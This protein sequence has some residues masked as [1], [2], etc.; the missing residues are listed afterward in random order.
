MS[1]CV[2]FA[3]QSAFLYLNF[4]C[5]LCHVVRLGLWSVLGPPVSV[6]SLV[7]ELACVLL[8]DCV[9]AF[10]CVLVFTGVCFACF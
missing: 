7:S 8:C 9:S 5:L 4:L 10:G 1:A 6:P 2:L 3:F